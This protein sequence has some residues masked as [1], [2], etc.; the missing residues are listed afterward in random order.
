VVKRGFASDTTGYEYKRMHPGGMPENHVIRLWHPSGMRF[1]YAIISGGVARQAS[2]NHRLKS[3]K[4]P[5]CFN[6][7]IQK[8]EEY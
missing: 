6:A 5:A 4:P 8:S 3:G 1:L 2:R 7:T